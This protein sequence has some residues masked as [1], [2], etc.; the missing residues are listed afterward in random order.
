MLEK[1]RRLRDRFFDY[2]IIGEYYDT[3]GDG[4]YYKKYLKRWHLRKR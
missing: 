4:R 3:N 2:E 1:L